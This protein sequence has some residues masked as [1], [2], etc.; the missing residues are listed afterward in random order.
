MHAASEA[1]AQTTGWMEGSAWRRLPKAWPSP[2]QPA[3]RGANVTTG[4]PHQREIDAAVAKTAAAATEMHLSDCSPS[5]VRCRRPRLG[6]SGGRRDRVGRGGAPER[7]M[8]F[9]CSESCGHCRRRGR[10]GMLRCC[11]AAAAAP[12]GARRGHVAVQSLQQRR[13]VDTQVRQCGFGRPEHPRRIIEQ[14]IEWLGDA[15]HTAGTG[16]RPTAQQAHN[17][18]QGERESESEPIGTVI[19]RIGSFLPPPWWLWCKWSSR[20]GLCCA[21]LCCASHRCA[22]WRHA[23]QD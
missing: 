16:G 6:G 3:G 8:P 1:H 7:C 23:A 15:A 18:R 2:S 22:V 21:G 20:L 10:S 11:A 4:A 17:A 9:R 12:D 19:R 5:W 13:P 14:K